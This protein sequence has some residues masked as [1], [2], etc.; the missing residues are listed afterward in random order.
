L[1]LHSILN[2]FSQSANVKDFNAALQNKQNCSL[3]G[4]IGSSLAFVAAASIYKSKCQNIF[5]L[6]DKESAAYFC[7]DLENLLNQS[8][9]DYSQKKVLFYPT[10]YKRPYETN[11]ADNANVLLRSDVISKVG[12]G[13]NVVIV[14]YP[15][16]LIEKVV[17]R[18]FL[19]KHSYK[20]SVNEAIDVDFLME[21]FDSYNFERVDFVIEPGQ[22]SVRG[23]IVDVFSFANDYPYRIELG[24]NN[25]ESLRSFDV[26]NQLSIK[27]FEQIAIIPNIQD[28]SVSQ[29]R[30]SI[31]DY[32]GNNNHIWFEDFQFAVDKIKSEFD[33][34]V[35]AFENINDK[36]NQ[37]LPEQLFISNNDFL[38]NITNNSIIEFGKSKTITKAISFQFNSS[39]QPSLNKNFELLFESL[40]NNQE[41]KIRNIIL[42][43]NEKQLHRIKTILDDIS[44]D[45]NIKKLDY[46]LTNISLHEG[47]IDKD[48]KVAYFT[49]H[50]IFDRYHRYSIHERPSSSQTI[51]LK[52]IYNLQPG[53][54]ITH[55]DHGVGRYDGLEKMEVNGKIQEVIR[56]VYAENDLLYI[57]IHSLHRISKYVGKD[58]TPP[59]LYRIGSGAWNKIK[60]KTKQRVKDI[61]ADLIKLYAKRKST[62]GFAYSPDTY[63]QTELEASFIYEDTPDQLKATADV[64]QDMERD[65]PMDRLVCGDVGFGKTEIAIRAAFKAVADSK[66]V[67]ILVPTTIL[68]LQHFKTFSERLNDFPC[69]VDYI[70]R[71]K[72]NKQ[73]KETLEKLVKG[74][75]DILIGTHRLLSKDI[76]F[77]DLGL[78]IVD[79][80]QKFGVAAKEKLRQFRVNVDTLTLTA[81][82]I[83]RTL[84]FSML[85]ARDLSIINTPPPNRHPIQTEQHSFDEK[86]I[87]SAILYE[88]SRGGQVFFVHNRINNLPELAG[89]IQRNLPDIKIGVAH[90][91]MDGHKLEQ[92]ML[93]FIEGYYDVLVSTTIIESGLDITNANTII[94][95]EAQNYGLSDLHQMRGRVGRNNKRA[96]CYLITP[97][98]TILTQ[99]ARRRLKALEDFS[100]LGSGFNIAM[101][102]LD[103][104]GA[105]DMLGGEQSGFISDIGYEMY[106]RILDEAIHELKTNEYKHLY[107]QEKVQDLPTDCIVETDMELLIPDN[108]VSNIPERLALYKELDN[109]E[110]DSELNTFSAKLKDIFGEIPNSTRELILSV[111]LRR[112]ARNIGFEKVIIKN[113][114]FVAYFISNPQ[115]EYFASELFSK[116]L[117]Y[118][119]FHPQTCKMKQVKDKL[120]VTFQNIPNIIQAINVIDEINNT[121]I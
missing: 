25:I 73:Q 14:T 98:K 72:S 85:G 103:I 22:F 65:Y 30:I 95:N 121:S 26:E 49:D 11:F 15:E 34:C 20:L 2:D 17:S 27:Q 40:V 47:F 76:Q 52:E 117:Q 92:I 106:Q 53:D 31:F 79:E 35:E 97:P 100:E 104:R 67:A 63:L 71:F 90:G 12:L 45:K 88:V 58:G 66:Q 93:D 8:E 16:A 81:T 23:G 5:I 42:S 120:S 3:N 86:L 37:L 107:T 112:L 89:M 39:P 110:T 119:Q 7:N 64:K 21:F 75:V 102:D 41:N 113:N 33:K 69:K 55:I 118:V 82:P 50:Q 46:S 18:S 99:E 80:E 13:Q 9:L 109:L 36:A 19:S 38:K 59:K 96:F 68:A 54:Y 43:D 44:A 4:L 56:L 62:N 115:S 91:Q 48:N 57:S 84:Q 70:N 83:P 51:T 94:I 87:T 1:K 108:Y 10:S 111:K 28:R 74:K 29:E 60:E 105:G 32:L 101:R 114:K 116:V 6:S 77:K 61:A 78:L 24:G